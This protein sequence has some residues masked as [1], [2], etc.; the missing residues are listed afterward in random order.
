MSENLDLVRSIYA[1]WERGDFSSAEWADRR[2]EAAE[3]WELLFAIADLAGDD[4]PERARDAAILLSAAKGVQEAT[5][6][7][8][9]Q[10]LE[11][12]RDAMGDRP[13]ISTDEVLTAVN[14]DDELP[15]GGWSESNGLDAR[16]L[17]RL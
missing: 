13:S 10:V 12:I 3:V 6:S 1:A 16:G 4:W 17:A 9:V 5:P 11:A 14:S 2:I 8:G 15:F 7:R